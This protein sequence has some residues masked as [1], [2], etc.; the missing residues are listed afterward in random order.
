MG[1]ARVI[2]AGQ[3]L[4]DDASPRNSPQESARWIVDQNHFLV[5]VDREVFALVL[6]CGDDGVFHLY[7][8]SVGQAQWKVGDRCVTQPVRRRRGFLQWPKFY[9]WLPV[10]YP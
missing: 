6:S 3:E 2:I 5:G 10:E 1:K 8:A 7:K 9:L 4:I